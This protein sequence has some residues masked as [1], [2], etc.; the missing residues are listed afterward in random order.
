MLARR[1]GAN[2]A[3]CESLFAGT[4][5]IVTADNVG[6]N[7]GLVNAETGAFASDS[8]LPATIVDVV[9]R[10]VDYRPREWALQHTGYRNSTALLNEVLRRRA[11]QA[12]EPWTQSIFKKKNMPNLVFA[13]DAERER[14]RAAL[15]AL[16]PYLAAGSRTRR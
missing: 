12:G 6:I 10:F 13:D 16:A 11:L 15:S 4:P 5:V 2:K 1:E 8:D 7:R 14:A 3:L 9:R